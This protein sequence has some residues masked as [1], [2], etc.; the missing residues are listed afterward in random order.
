MTESNE[1]YTTYHMKTNTK[2]KPQHTT[3]RWR[4]GLTAVIAMTLILVTGRLIVRAVEQ[5]TITAW[6]RDTIVVFDGHTFPLAY[7]QIKDGTTVVGTTTADGNGDFYKEIKAVSGGVH[8]FNVTSTDGDGTET[9]PASYTI[10]VPPQTTTTISNILVPS[11]LYI[12]ETSLQINDTFTPRGS[13]YK[14]STIEIY[15]NGSKIGEATTSSNGTWSKNLTAN[16]GAGTFTITVIVV[17]G[18]NQSEPSKGININVATAPTPTPTV[19]PTPKPTSTPTPTPKTTTTPQPTP[20][21]KPTATPTPTPKSCRRSD[22]NCDTKVNLVDFSILLYHW[23]T[24]HAVADINKD[25]NVNLTDFSI[26]LYDW[27][28]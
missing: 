25:G 6:V 23:G 20:T 7:V 19:T 15:A 22:L 14:G 3:S 13:A 17:N 24:N 18:G 4:R 8:T 11:T 16:F 21:P 2:E 12:D 28:G 1:P 10:D 9:G 26:M 5:V 27:T